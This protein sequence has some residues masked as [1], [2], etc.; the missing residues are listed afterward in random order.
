MFN[1]SNIRAT[2]L[3]HLLDLEGPVFSG[4]YRKCGKNVLNAA[5]YLVERCGVVSHLINILM[6][7]F[8]KSGREEVVYLVAGYFVHS[9]C[10]N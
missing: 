5:E 1:K 4:K 2:I 9:T 8:M 10:S 3:D 6:K 7:T